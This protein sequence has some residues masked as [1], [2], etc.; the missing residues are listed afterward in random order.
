M[1][2]FTDQPIDTPR[3]GAPRVHID[4]RVAQWCEDTYASGKALQV[5]LSQEHPDTPGFLRMLRIY[6][7]RQ[8]KA[9]DTQFVEISG[10]SY[11]RFKMRDKKKY[12]R[13]PLP[14]EAK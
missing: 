10:V 7:N 1:V 13:A 9:V 6:G 8:R 5:P 3:Q 4:P 2:E 14:R 12:N 11:L